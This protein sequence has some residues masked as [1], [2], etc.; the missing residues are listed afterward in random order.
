MLK[1]ICCVDKDYGIGKNNKLPWSNKEEMNHFRTTTLNK[2]VVMGH[3]TFE[4]MGNKVLASRNNII[5][6]RNK[7]LK[8]DGATVSDNIKE[9]I[10]LSKKEDV[11]IIGGKQIN[12]LF[13][14]YVDEIILSQ[15]NEKYDCDLFWNPSLK[16]FKLTNCEKKDGF[17]ILTYKNFYNKILNGK[18][19]QDFSKQNILKT[20]N[21][22]IKKYKAIPKLIIVQVGDDFASNIYIKNKVI[23]AKELKFDVEVIKLDNNTNQENLN[24][25]IIKLNN[26]HT[27]NGILVQSPLPKHLNIN[28]ISSI[29]NIDK[30]VDCFN[31]TNL[32]LIFRGDW[33]NIYTYPCTPY[34]VMELLKY[35]KVKLE[36]KH[37]VIIG[38]SNIVSKPLLHLMLKENATVTICHSKTKNINQYLKK[39]D[40]ICSAAGVMNLINKDN[41]K[42]NAV[43]IDISINRD[44]DNKICGDVILNDVIDK[45]K[46]ITPVPGGI[47]PMTLIILFKNLMNLY[48]KQM[49]QQDG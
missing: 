19:C 29:I 44:H 31:E 20:A 23:L 4:S 14:N 30:D 35:Y 3:K 48:Q 24:N 42:K 46:Y 37:V 21:V 10:K 49:E 17:N 43:I 26:D 11:Y 25:L 41:I 15:L 16:F 2:T 39:A 36:S 27:V 5:F 40:I 18:V 32:G 1:I 45:V 34:G 7:E 22:L 13:I 28:T 38:R 12:D 47:G 6:T 33:T 9:I 8:I